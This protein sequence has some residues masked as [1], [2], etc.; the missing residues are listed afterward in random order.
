MSKTKAGILDDKEAILALDR[1]GLFKDEFDFPQNLKKAVENVKAFTLPEKVKIRHR[2][3]RYKNIENVVLAGMG[4]SAIVGDILKDWIG[5][6]IKVPM[7]IVRGY[8]L[9]AY[10]DDDSLVFFISYSGNTEET[11]SCMLDAV[12]RGCKIISISSNGALGRATQALGLPLI[13]LP[14]MAAARAS[15]PYLFAPLPYLL[16]KVGI[17]PLDKVEKEMNDAIGVVGKLAKEL[18]I[19]VPFGKN[20]AKSIAFQIFGTVPVVYCYGPYKSV[21]LRF[22]E[23]VNE[24]CKLPARC[25]VFPELNHN[26]IMS[27]EASTSI[28]KRYSLILLRDFEVEPSEV[29]ARIDVLKERFF[30][31]KAK[32]V[33]TVQPRGETLLGRIFS[34]F[35]S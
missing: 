17:L 27:W 24:N 34:S 28:L 13:E 29:R 22:K 7:Q 21:G 30:L 16:V 3:I 14:K 1:S 31:K 9:P 11:L 12:Q 32:S 33:I 10:L 35:L 2:M 8:N 5:N 15:L 20:F 6:E 25:D 4:G 18:A 19:E 23:Q 26:E